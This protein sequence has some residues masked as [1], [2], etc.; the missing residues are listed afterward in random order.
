[1]VF[2]RFKTI[3][4]VAEGP[5]IADK[6]PFQ[7]NI[8]LLGGISFKKGC[9]LGQELISRSYHTGIVR[10][11][12]FPFYL[13]NEKATLP[14]NSII[15]TLAGK[16]LGKVVHSDGNTGLVLLDYL[17]ISDMADLEFTSPEA[18]EIMSPYQSEVSK[19]LE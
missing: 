15:K 2:E 6:I 14:L 3:N 4:G 11:R 19:Y 10:R 8:D 9:Y 18:G 17:T 5:L 16:E 1:M 13:S 7:F 12:V